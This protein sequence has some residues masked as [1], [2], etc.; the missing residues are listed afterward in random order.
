MENKSNGKIVIAILVM[1]VVAL[2]IVGVTYAY[3]TTQIIQNTKEESVKVDAGKLIAT[4]DGGNDINVSNIFPGWKSD[5]NTFYDVAKIVDNKLV[6]TTASTD[7]ERAATTADTAENGL[8]DPIQFTVTNDSDNQDSDI[9]YIVN[10]DVTTLDFSQ[11][12]LDAGRLTATLYKGDYT[13]GSD[14]KAAVLAGTEV[15]KIQIKAETT[16]RFATSAAEIQTLAAKGDSA[17]YYVVFEYANVDVAQESQN[18]TLEAKV[19]ITGV[20]QNGSTWYDA[21]N[22]EITF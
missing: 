22:N 3:F 20:Q 12:D 1:F 14:D 18:K 10:L 11:T 2:S 17:K 6:S 21:D 16:Y 13:T 8:R 15:A 19:S 9:S 5:G 4:Y 7:A